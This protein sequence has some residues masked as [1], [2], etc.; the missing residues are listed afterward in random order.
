MEE[1]SL[2]CRSA[3]ESPDEALG[4]EEHIIHIIHMH[5]H[6]QTPRWPWLVERLNLHDILFDE[7]SA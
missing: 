1:R 7:Q 4:A 5:T 6:V 2:S 3:T